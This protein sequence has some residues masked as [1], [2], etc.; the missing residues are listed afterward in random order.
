MLFQVCD[1]YVGDSCMDLH[2]IID[3]QKASDGKIHG[4]PCSKGWLNIIPITYGCTDNSWDPYWANGRVRPTVCVDYEEK[5]E[6]YGCD[7]SPF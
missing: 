2:W 1:V 3:A 7:R 5:Y 6:K 4:N